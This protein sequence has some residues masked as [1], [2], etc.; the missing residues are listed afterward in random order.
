MAQHQMM[1][2]ICDD[3]VVNKRKRRDSVW[4][5]R[6][7]AMQFIAAEPINRRKRHCDCIPDIRSSRFEDYTS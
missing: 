4:L 1:S 7:S 2:H 6:T 3:D 5:P